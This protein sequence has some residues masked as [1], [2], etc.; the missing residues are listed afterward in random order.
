[1]IQVDHQIFKISEI[2]HIKVDHIISD[3]EFIFSDQ[4]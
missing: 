4:K 2:G 3:R 1:M